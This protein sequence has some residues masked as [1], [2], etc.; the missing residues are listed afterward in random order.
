M[1][2][3]FGEMKQRYKIFIV[4]GIIIS[5]IM[6]VNFGRQEIK[7]PEIELFSEEEL[8]ILKQFENE[9]LNFGLSVGSELNYKYALQRLLWDELKIEANFIMFETYEEAKLATINKEIDI[10]INKKEVEEGDDLLWISNPVTNTQFLISNH[11]HF[12]RDVNNLK[13]QKIGFLR[14]SITSKDFETI[15]GVNQFESHFF[16]TIDD[17]LDALENQE[18][19]ALITRRENAQYALIEREDVELEF[20]FQNK[21]LT[22]RLGTAKTDVYEGLEIFQEIMNSSRMEVFMEIL[23]EIENYYLE[24]LIYEY[25][26]K[27]YES[28]IK[29]IDPI[30]VGVHD[31]TYPFSYLNEEGIHQG[32]YIEMLEL[33]SKSTGIP[34]RIKNT[35]NTNFNQLIRQLTTNEIQLLLGLSNELPDED[36]VRI[37]GIEIQD[38]LISIGK[39]GHDIE[40]R[41]LFDL[42]FGVVFDD[43]DATEILGAAPF[44]KFNNYEEAFEALYKQDVNLIIGRESVLSYYR[45]VLGMSLLTQTSHINR[46]SSHSILGNEYSEEINLIMKDIKRLYNLLYFGTQNVRWTNQINNYQN[47]Y[48]ELR[49][50]WDFTMYGFV[51]I[52]GIG[53][54]TLVLVKEIDNR[55][56]KEVNSK[57]PLTQLYNKRAYEKKCLDLIKKNSDKLGIFFFIDLNDFKKIND[58]YGHQVG[59]EL[60]IIFSNSLKNFADKLPNTI[61]FRISGDEFGLFSCGYHSQEEINKLIDKI[62][63]NIVV[64][65]LDESNLS[66]TISYSIGGSIYNVDTTDF[67][68]L[69]KYADL[70]MYQAKRTKKGAGKNLELFNL[71]LLYIYQKET[72]IPQVMDTI[73]VNKDIYPVYQPIYSLKDIKIFGY[74]GLSRTKNPHI[75][76]ITTLIELAEKTKKIQELDLLMME[77]VLKGFKGEGKIFVN[78]TEQSDEY[79]N[80]YFNQLINI[81]K[82]MKIPFEN[83]IVELSER[84][85]WSFESVSILKKYREKYKFLIAID[86]FGVGF[87]NSNL[88]LMVKP[89]IVKIDKLFIQE[90]HKSQEKY[91]IVKSFITMLKANEIK[92]ICEGIECLEDLELLKIL[93]SD[94]GQGNYLGEPE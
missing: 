25:I 69:R 36:V 10:L 90:I 62:P 52:V 54:I 31:S 74:E 57:D 28:T 42:N 86:D 11:S 61:C 4:F 82:E 9:T 40:R 87:S 24:T 5:S 72:F 38:N 43:K 29:D 88:L 17:A 53:I 35:A 50:Q 79:L 21:I 51:A 1:F 58:V 78:I 77:N 65:G 92:I 59:D 84:T 49:H 94:Y 64:K 85:N 3:K 66:V 16:N 48:N 71:S 70:A 56:L 13:N 91:N 39:Y 60:L 15:I 76:T 93:G 47:R 2:H 32:I 23:E 34:F 67:D 37:S 89:D 30:I 12:L 46:I 75:S 22:A 14:N 73:L 81:T 41:A 63:E 33:F 6:I 80:Q 55:K 27:K 26:Q 18:I 44:K 19:T 83:I 45:D 7:E 8:A 68:R 20:I